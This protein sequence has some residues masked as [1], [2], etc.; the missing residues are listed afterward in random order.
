VPGRVLGSRRSA[1][2]KSA[3]VAS[4]FTGAAEREPDADQGGGLRE[5]EADPAGRPHGDPVGGQEHRPPEAARMR[6]HVSGR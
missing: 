1:P 5:A 3:F 6:P 2:C 4:T